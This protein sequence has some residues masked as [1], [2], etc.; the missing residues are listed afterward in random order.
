MDTSPM[1]LVAD[2][3]D[4]IALVDS[5]VLVVR[6]NLVEAEQINDAIDGLNASGDK[7]LG[8]VFNDVFPE[9]LGGFDS[10]SYHY[11]QYEYGGAG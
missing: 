4:L 6:Q 10:Y 8:C 7:L 9:Y 3:E 11:K 5:A 2:A 1:A